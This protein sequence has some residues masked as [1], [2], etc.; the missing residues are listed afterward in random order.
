[1]SSMKYTPTSQKGLHS[2]RSASSLKNVTGKE[3]SGTWNVSGTHALVSTLLPGPSFQKH[4]VSVFLC[5]EKVLK[6]VPTICFAK[7]VRLYEKYFSRKVNSLGTFLI[8]EV[9]FE[10]IS[11]VT[12]FDSMDR[13]NFA[14]S[15]RDSPNRFHILY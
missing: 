14:T 9:D 11:F 15:I 12:I 6:R 3:T 13:D 7:K 5:S 10:N 8:V 4:R 2:Y 1:M